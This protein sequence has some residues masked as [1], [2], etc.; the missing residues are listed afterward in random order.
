MSWILLDKL[1]DWIRKL[2]GARGM[3]AYYLHGLW[4]QRTVTVCDAIKTDSFTQIQPLYFFKPNHI[5]EGFCFSMFTPIPVFI[6]QKSSSPLERVIFCHILSSATTENSQHSMFLTL[7]SLCVA[8]TKPQ[9]CISKPLPVFCCPGLQSV[10]LVLLNVRWSSVGRSAC[11]F[12]FPCCFC[13]FSG[14]GQMPT[15][16]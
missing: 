4:N 8:S 6:P 3:E 15:Y 12:Y 14:R 5:K 2:R 13:V 10:I 11:M 7:P 9:S 1:F 16:L